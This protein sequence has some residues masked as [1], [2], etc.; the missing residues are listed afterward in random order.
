MTLSA[1]SCCHNCGLSYARSTYRLSPEPPPVLRTN[2]IHLSVFWWF[3]SWALTPR[4]S[5]VLPRVNLTDAW[6]SPQIFSEGLVEVEVARLSP[7][8]T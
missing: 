5:A 3:Q 1:V 4:K 8:C 2:N 7:Y 6:S